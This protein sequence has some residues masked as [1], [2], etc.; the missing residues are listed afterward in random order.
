[1]IVP[2][3]TSNDLSQEWQPP[4]P[5]E[6]E[7]REVVV[8]A[9]S[10][11]GLELETTLSSETAAVEDPVEARVIRDVRAEGET[12]IPAG[13]RAFGTVVDV[14]R[15]GRFRE[16]ARLGVRFDTL[17]LADGTRLPMSTETIYRLGN[18]PGRSTAA[19]IGG[20]AV[21]GAILGGILGGSRG[22]AIGASS[23]AGAGTAAVYAGGRSE[24]T[25]AS[26]LEVT[27]RFLSDV[28]VPL[29]AR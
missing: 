17:V 21:A 11:I 7:L 3:Q 18:A 1:V 8:R 27:V 25:F 15:G 19:K 20:G 29:P 9:D 24:A 28:P 26:G 22:A 12:A 23:G 10:V 2:A 5:E 16:Q 6:P 14:E 4:T 13:A